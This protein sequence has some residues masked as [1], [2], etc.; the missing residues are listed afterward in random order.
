[1]HDFATSQKKFWRKTVNGYVYKTIFCDGKLQVRYRL[2]MC[3]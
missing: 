2:R 3:S 1:M